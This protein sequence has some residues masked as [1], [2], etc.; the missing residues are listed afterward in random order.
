MKKFAG[1]IASSILA[2]DMLSAAAAA[3]LVAARNIRAGA[4]ITASDIVSPEDVYAMRRAVNII[5][6][7]VRRTVYRG[8]P[9]H[10]EALQQP[11]LVKRNAIVQMEFSK[12]SMNISAEGRA[13]DKGAM[14]DR[15]RVMNLISKRIVVATVSGSD[16]VRAK[17]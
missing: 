5:G 9:L 15:I 11:T 7:E 10:E 3:E 17:L 6:L 4:V 2:S 13:L 12:G 1:I 16:S 14:G 8:Q